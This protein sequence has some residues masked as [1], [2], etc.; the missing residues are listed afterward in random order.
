MAIT[1][2]LELNSK[3]KVDSTHGIML[4]ITENRKMKRIST[5]IFVKEEDFN[6]EADYGKWIRK[7]NG[8]HE[9]LNEELENF[10]DAAKNA[11]GDLE[12]NKQLP[13]PKNIIHEIKH[14]NTGSFIEYYEQKLEYYLHNKSASYYKH[15]KSK[16]NNLKKYKSDLLFAEVNVS[17]L[18]RYETYLISKKE[19]NQNSVISNLRAIRTI[20][21][22][23][24]SEEVHEGKNPFLVKKLSEIKANKQRLS[25]EEIRRL[26]AL[27]LEENT[28][29]WHVRNYFL[30]SFYCAG[31]RIRDII[32][33]KWKDIRGNKLQHTINKNGELQEITL[34]PE[35]LNILDMY[36][37]NRSPE[38]FVFPILD[39]S[40]KVNES[41]A[42]DN[43]ISSKTAVINLG[44]KSIADMA[45]I[46]INLTFHISR[47]SYADM[48][49]KAGVSVY[50]IKN[51]LK[52]SDIKVTERY[53]KG[54]D[55]D[56]ADEVH[57][58]AMEQRN[59]QHTS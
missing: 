52:Q 12:K 20:L 23:A 21:Y 2:K 26:E 42:F 27:E 58:R 41:L 45:E 24:Y 54:I 32:Q 31:K 5:G 43:L 33:L 28:I 6:K 35:A 29:L 50:D 49:R 11:K 18:N 8:S 3:P 15:L 57:V 55:I 10:I 17:F 4:R 13:T 44:L 1:Y 46:Q 38:N 51:L 25:I 19:L 48:L 30:F 40:I 22:D 56:A 59:K 9:K 7:I 14:K 39:N 47:H 34:I 36:S 16:F 53:L 37:D